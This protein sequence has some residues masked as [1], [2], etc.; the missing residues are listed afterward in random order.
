MIVKNEEHNLPRCLRSIRGAV[1]ELIVVDTGS[2]DNTVEIAKRH[3]AR[4][5]HHP[6]QNDFSLHRNQSFGY[7]TG[8][9]ILQIDA[10]EELVFSNSKPKTLANWLVDIPKK[11]NA[12][13][14][15]M[16]DYRKGQCIANLD[17]V[18]VFRK[19]QVVYKGIVHN[20]PMFQGQVVYF[21][22]GRLNHYGYDLTNEQKAIKRKRTVGLL[23]KRLEKNPKDYDAMFY[24]AEALGTYADSRD[25]LKWA[26][27]YAELRKH[28]GRKFNPSIFYLI[29]NTCRQLGEWDIMR[30]WLNIGQSVIPKDLDLSMCQIQLGVHAKD[31]ALIRDGATNFVAA[32]IAFEQDRIKRGGGFFFHR[33]PDSLAYAIYQL[34]LCDL[35]AATIGMGQLDVVLKNLPDPKMADHFR[36]ELAKNLKSTGWART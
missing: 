5:F 16:Q 2:T 9:W 35:E 25:G 18:R 4:V 21:P 13:A 27:K 31:R 7:A 20:E 22:H 32:Y 26:I 19:N 14:V 1:D 10:D 3:G 8:D 6:W 17:V 34:I 23:E 30:H 36:E 11:H 15:P 29:V 12:V 28:I 33:R 24:M